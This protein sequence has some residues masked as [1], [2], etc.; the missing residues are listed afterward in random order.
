MCFVAVN[1]DSSETFCFVPGVI[2]VCKNYL[3]LCL[4]ILNFFFN[5]HISPVLSLFVTDLTLIH[6]F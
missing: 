5:G 1:A 3:L 6:H 4:N 2:I